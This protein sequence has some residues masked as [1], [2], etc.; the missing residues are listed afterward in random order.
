MGKIKTFSD[1]Q[2]GVCS[3]H[4]N[5]SLDV[6]IKKVLIKEECSWTEFQENSYLRYAKT[7]DQLRK[8]RQL[9]LNEDEVSPFLQ[10]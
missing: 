2:P 5:L 8:G 9:N 6:L 4:V 3:W 7:A 10:F 1:S